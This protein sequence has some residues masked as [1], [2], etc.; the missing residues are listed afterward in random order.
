MAL[1]FGPTTHACGFDENLYQGNQ[2]T[3]AIRSQ[4]II[5]RDFGIKIP[6]EELIRYASEK[7][8][9]DSDGTPMACIGNLLDT[10]H[11]ST[12]RVENATIYDLI[13][14]LNAGHRVIVG[15]DAH[16]IWEDQGPIG[17]WLSRHIT[18]PNH[19]LIVTSLNVD[20]E[21]PTKTTVLLTDPGSGEI[22]E[23]PYG[24]FAHSWKDADCF[25]VAT[26]DAAPYQ[27]NPDTRQME[28]SNFATLYTMSEFPFTNEFADIYAFEEADNYLPYY[29]NGH[30]DQISD[31][32]SFADFFEAFENHDFGRLANCFEDLACNSYEHFASYCSECFESF[33][34]SFFTNIVDAE[35]A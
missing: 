3:C 25:M 21:D 24:K 4:E 22:I 16:E 5:L 31:D 12:H 20:L 15:I 6:Q 32:F 9:F 13:N 8:W 7:G 27:Y 1:N 34:L 18:D 23:C 10:C 28:F 17:N 29:E 35:T 14:E 30:I 33:D 26:N 11:V 19:A 2:P